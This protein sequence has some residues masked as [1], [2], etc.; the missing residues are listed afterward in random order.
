M[1]DREENVAGL[2]KS[3]VARSSVEDR[4]IAVPSARRSMA[5]M[6]PW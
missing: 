6:S 1:G 2:G 5:V 4:E 3:F